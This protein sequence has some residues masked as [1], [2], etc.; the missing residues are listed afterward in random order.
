VSTGEHAAE[1]IGSHAQGL[2]N[3][4][5]ALGMKMDVRLPLDGRVRAYGLPCTPTLTRRSILSAMY[6]AKSLAVS[7]AVG[8]AVCPYCAAGNKTTVRLTDGSF[9][10]P[11]CGH[12][13]VS[14]ESTLICNCVKCWPQLKRA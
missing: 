14:P 9:V 1:Y 6:T 13:V 3:F 10:C 2:T 11:S 12:I 5:G 7:K 8:T 4:A